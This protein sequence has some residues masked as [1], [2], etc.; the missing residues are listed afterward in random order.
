[1]V[2]LFLIITSQFGQGAPHAFQEKM[3]AP[4]NLPLSHSSAITIGLDAAGMTTSPAATD[5]VYVMLTSAVVARKRVPA[6]TWSSIW[7]RR[8][9]GGPP[10]GAAPE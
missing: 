7:Y 8:P 10:I 2:A 4:Q 5:A 1:M 6:A 9:P 3:I